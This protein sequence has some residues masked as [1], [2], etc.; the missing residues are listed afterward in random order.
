[1]DQRL[2]SETTVDQRR[3]L[4]TATYL[5]MG[6]RYNPV[7]ATELLRG[8]TNMRESST[9]QAILD[10]G[11]VE[12]RAEGQV[13]G[14]AEHAR[15]LLVTLGTR[16]FGPPPQRVLAVINANTDPAD[17]DRLTVRVLDVSGWDELLS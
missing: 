3:T 7:E 11:R 2:Q 17:L 8:V 1:M 9:Y 6:L 4:W 13:Q 12:G 15:Q 14:R 16:R 5:L 10:E